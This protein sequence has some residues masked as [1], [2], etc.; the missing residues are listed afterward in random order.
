[1]LAH[2]HILRH[3]HVGGHQL[4]ADGGALPAAWLCRICCHKRPERFPGKT[5][6][7]GVGLCFCV[8]VRHLDKPHSERI[9][10]PQ[11]AK[12]LVNSA[13]GSYESACGERPWFYQ[14]I[15][16]ELIRESIRERRA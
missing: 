14:A 1:M 9:G 2:G 3:V 6:P 4:V 12:A 13:M 8:R 10:N 5:S 7:E 11:V 16:R 15:L